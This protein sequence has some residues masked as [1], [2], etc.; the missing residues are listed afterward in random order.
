MEMNK[1]VENLIE[2]CEELKTSKVLFADKKIN[3]ILQSIATTPEVYSLLEECLGEFD[4]EKEFAKAFTMDA[5]GNNVF[6]MP[7]EEYKILALVFCL[8]ADIGKGKIKFDE[9]VETYFAD[10][11]GKID[12]PIFADKVVEPFIRLLR[13]TFNAFDDYSLTSPEDEGKARVLPFPF[14]RTVAFQMQIQDLPKAFAEI[15]DVALEMFERLKEERETDA[16]IDAEQLLNALVIACMDQDLDYA[17]AMTTALK[18]VCH[19]VR[20]LRHMLKEIEE[21]IKEQVMLESR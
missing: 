2:L 7:K 19:Y 8:F 13:E 14:E 6:V 18:Y 5:N 16:T 10:E 15:C 21:I 1:Q 11:R 4:K 20:P 3:N 17:S 9:L 12:T